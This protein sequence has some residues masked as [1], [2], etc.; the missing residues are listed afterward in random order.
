VAGLA[1]LAAI[2]DEGIVEHSHKMGDL[3][4]DRFAPLVERYELLHEVRGK[5]QMIGIEFGEP[6]SRRLR[7]WW[8]VTER[9]RP[10]F[11]SQTVVLPLFQRHR[12]LTQVA[13]D[14]VNVIK[15]LPPLT[16]GEDEVDL[17]VSAFD[18]VLRDAHRAGGLLI[19]TTS[20]M[21]R[22][23]MRRAHRRPVSRAW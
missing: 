14:G 21:A 7:R 17:V 1:T 6:E 4:K 11:F 16:V 3:W 9:I 22:G 18:G 5:G 19:E 23:A 2:D 13:A 12:L 8:R 15:L 20:Q 10:A